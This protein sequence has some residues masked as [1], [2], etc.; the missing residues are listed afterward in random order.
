MAYN[1]EERKHIFEQI[2]VLVQSEQ[3]EIF[4]IIRKTKENYTENSNGIFFDLS[5]VSDDTF[6]QIK[7]YIAFCLKTRQEDADR[8]KD[9][10]I[11]RIQNENY[12]NEDESS[13]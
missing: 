4:R 12:I 1:Y 6:N 3:E 13:A 9:L 7:E 10:E 8:L 2:K 11:I 5:I